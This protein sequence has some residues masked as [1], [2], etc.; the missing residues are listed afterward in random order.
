M[1]ERPKGDFQPLKDC[2]R[3]HDTIEPEHSPVITFE[4]RTAAQRREVAIELLAELEEEPQHLPFEIGIRDNPEEVG[5]RIRQLLGINAKKQHQWNDTNEA[6]NT[7]RA[8]AEGA[9]ILVFQTSKLPLSVLR[10]FSISQFP[11][12]VVVLNTKDSESARIFTL[13]HELA[14]ILLHQGAIC[15]IY[16]EFERHPKEQAIEVFCNHV[17]GATLVPRARLVEA[18]ERLKRTGRATSLDEYAA[19][20][21]R[22]FRVSREVILRRCLTFGFIKEATYA[23]KRE[24]LLKEYEQLRKRKKASGKPVIV[25]LSRRVLSNAGLPFVNIVLSSYYQERI[26]SSDVSTFLEAK[27][28]HLP[29]IES[30]ATAKSVKYGAPR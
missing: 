6:L 27:L 8:A 22:L 7:W 13:A 15:D 5:R 9:G 21:A 29:R 23:K 16:E 14:H 3:I 30:E 26:T 19:N 2:R 24:E 28:K 17:A 25:P 18:Y 20:L 4:V 10:G 11:L 1:P 12:P